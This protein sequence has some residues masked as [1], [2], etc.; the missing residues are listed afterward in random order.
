MNKYFVILAAGIGSRFGYKIPKQ[1]S[2]IGGKYVLKYSIDKESLINL[3][4]D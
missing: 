2:C 4:I 3:F 1:Y